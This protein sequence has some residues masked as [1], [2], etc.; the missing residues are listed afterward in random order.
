MLRT[1]HLSVCLVI[2]VDYDVLRSKHLPFCSVISLDYDM[3]RT[4]HQS[5][6]SVISADYGMLRTKHLNTCLLGHFRGLWHAQDKSP[7]GV[8][9]GVF[10]TLLNASWG[11]P[12]HCSYFA[13]SLLNYKDNGICGLT[14]TSQGTPVDSMCIACS[15]D[16]VIDKVSA[17]SRVLSL[18][19]I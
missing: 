13:A 15:C 14:V 10:G 16:L 7:T 8:F 3:L 17:A 9:E 1:K 6:C 18:I 5:V 12:P 4:D 11:F 2:S 19:H